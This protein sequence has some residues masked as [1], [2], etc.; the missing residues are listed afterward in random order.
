[1]TFRSHGG[2]PVGGELSRKRNERFGFTLVELLVVIGIIAV[3]IGIL[4][5]TLARA[6]E[7]A[8]ASKCLNNMR[9]ITVAAISFAQEHQGW[10]VGR[11]GGGNIPYNPAPGKCPFLGTV[12]VTSPGNWIAWERQI[13][14]ISGQSTPGNAAQ[15]ITYSALAR[16]M[17]VKQ[18]IHKTPQEANSISEKLDELFRCPSDNLAN[19]PNP[20]K[21][22]RYS[23][24]MNDLFL[25]GTGGTPQPADVTSYPAPPTPPQKGQRNGFFFNGKIGSIRTPSQYVMLVCQDE[26]NLD[27]GVFKPNAAKWIADQAGDQ[28]AARHENKFKSQKTVSGTGTNTNAR[29]NVGFCDGHA[30]FLSRK[31]A[32]SQRYSG[33]PLPDPAGF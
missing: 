23:Y 5:P 11:A 1:M 24:S 30:E 12:D 29:G 21:A 31:E 17:S 25:P 33:H 7:A 15:N 14:P 6:R 27:D 8:R 4:L 9:Q 10:M 26:Q 20:G 3:M 18:K 13:D 32:I 22:Y 16:Y 2:N 19:R 28:V